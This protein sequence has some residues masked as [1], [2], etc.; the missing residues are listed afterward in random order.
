MFRQ[1]GCFQSDYAAGLINNLCDCFLTPSPPKIPDTPSQ[2]ESPFLRNH[3][4]VILVVWQLSNEQA[5]DD[6]VFTNHLR[7]Y[8]T[9][10]K[11]DYSHLT[12][13]QTIFEGGEEKKKKHPQSSLFGILS[14][15]W[16]ISVSALV[17]L[18]QLKS[19]CSWT[20]LNYINPKWQHFSSKLPAQTFHQHI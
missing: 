12:W 1:T 9:R 8:F 20:A 17:Y 13:N 3:E 16:L 14:S 15:K 2:T 11:H 4:H 5:R 19:R 6:T 7:S 18:I 10:S